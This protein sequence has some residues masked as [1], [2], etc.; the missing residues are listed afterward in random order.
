MNASVTTLEREIDRVLAP[1][2]KPAPSAATVRRV[3]DVVRAA[4]LRRGS[5]WARWRAAG[6]V[7]AA[8]ALTASLAGIERAAPP[9]LSGD[10]SAVAGGL[11]G[12]LGAD[13]DA[14]SRAMADS[15]E[16]VQ[17]LFMGAWLFNPSDRGD[18]SDAES[19]D[20]LKLLESWRP[21]V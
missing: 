2:A 7:A 3:Q 1:L 16:V 10:A 8:L 4:A 13:F 21:G 20:L 6:G 19:E 17:G 14:W 18:A 9:R 15:T 11:G 5:G 12:A